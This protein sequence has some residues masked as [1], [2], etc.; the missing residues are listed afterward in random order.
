[1]K[2]WLAWFSVLVAGVA[3]RSIEQCAESS[4][5]RQLHVVY[6]HGDRTPTSLYPKD[7]NSPSDFPEGLGHITHKGKNDQYN[8]GRYLRVKYEDFLSYD[9]NEMKARSSG[10][11]RCLESIQT[12]L[13]GLYP[14]RGKKVWNSEVDWQPVPIQTMPVDLDGMLYEDAICPKAEEELDRIRQSPEGA[15]VLNSNANLMRTLQE[16]SGK[17]M[18]DWVSVRDLLDT[19]TIERSRGLKIPDWALPLWG[20]MTKVAK[21]TTILNYKSPTYNKFRAGLLIRD[22]VRH[23]DQVKD[24]NSNVKLYMYAAHDVAIA[25]FTSAFGV[26]NQ[27]AVPSSTAVI[28][29]LHEDANGNFFI[30]MLFKN[31]TTRKPYRLE[32]PGCEGFRC[33]LTTF[34]D[35]AKPYIPDD[36]RKECGLET[37]PGGIDLFP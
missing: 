18:N 2:L 12:N 7:P 9:P 31:D 14:P 22:I 25:A 32:I 24:G 26:F 36:W 29:E 8:L 4:S 16:L 30:Q 23:A 15:E 33:S 37:L 1:M 3:S 27:L 5:L 13:A 35:L 28:T 10:R 6:R 11:E 34:K 21:Y 19:L 20:N 17:K